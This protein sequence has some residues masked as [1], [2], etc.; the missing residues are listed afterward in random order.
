MHLGK[1]FLLLIAYKSDKEPVGQFLI[2]NY[3]TMRCQLTLNFF[4]FHQ[5]I[6]LLRKSLQHADSFLLIDQI[7][8]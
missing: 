3:L 2:A 6:S 4:H 7:G 8:L 5:L 1:H